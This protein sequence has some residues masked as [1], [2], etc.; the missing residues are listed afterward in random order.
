MPF[1]DQ[2]SIRN[3]VGQRKKDAASS[4][5]GYHSNDNPYSEQSKKLDCSH[6][7]DLDVNPN[8]YNTGKKFLELD[9]V[10]DVE[11]ELDH[12]ADFHLAAGVD[13]KGNSPP[14][15]VSH[16]LNQIFPGALGSHSDERSQ[17]ELHSSVDI[18]QV[19]VT[20][21]R[22]RVLESTSTFEDKT[23]LHFVIKHKSSTVE[24]AT[25]L[26]FIIIIN[27]IRTSL[28]NYCQMTTRRREYSF[29][30]SHPTQTNPF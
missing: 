27:R 7:V 21:V 10:P 15:N 11:L 12:P 30:S 24:V 28:I 25:N 23:I 9:D 2:T 8:N 6:L 22:T 14:S 18:F 26:F 17:S 29:V 19:V 3:N 1:Q 16:D 13:K 20:E 5:E 4:L